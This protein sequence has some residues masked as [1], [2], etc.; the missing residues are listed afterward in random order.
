MDRKRGHESSPGKAETGKANASHKHNTTDFMRGR[1]ETMPMFMLEND[2]SCDRIDLNDQA[3][4][5]EQLE[6]A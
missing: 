1:A 2:E 6:P 3:A 5:W 4:A